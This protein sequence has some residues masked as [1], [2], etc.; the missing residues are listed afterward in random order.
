MPIG[1]ALALALL[2]GEAAAIAWSVGI[3][4]FVYLETRDHARDWVVKSTYWA[5]PLDGV[6]IHRGPGGG[7]FIEVGGSPVSNAF[8][9]GLILLPILILLGMW[10]ESRGRFSSSEG[11]SS[12]IL[13]GALIPLADQS[14]WSLVILILVLGLVQLRR[15]DRELIGTKASGWT[16]ASVI[17]LLTAVFV[18]SIRDRA[19]VPIE[20]GGAHLLPLIIGVLVYVESRSRRW[21]E[22][23]ILASPTVV[24][25]LS[26]VVASMVCLPDDVTYRYLELYRLAI[27]HIVIAGAILVIECGGRGEV[28]PGTRLAG[29]VTMTIFAVLS[30]SIFNINGGLAV[31]GL[32]ERVA[33]DIAVVAP[34]VVV[35]RMLKEIEDLSEQAR[36]MGAWTLIAL[37]VMG[38]TDVSGGYWQYQCSQS[39]HTEPQ[40]T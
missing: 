34:L 9:M 4:A 36:R 35:D 29:A 5:R 22:S 40:R 14:G 1:L 32:P 17:A 16:L 23:T 38:G 15:A 10:S 12:S 8:V 25:S 30:W 20:F 3:A 2:E 19:E 39:L 21:G 33:R 31:I 26:L 24:C 6:R 27:A 11:S 7:V 18:L 37:L 13:A 28:S